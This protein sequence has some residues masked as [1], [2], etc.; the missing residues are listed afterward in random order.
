M[1]RYDYRTRIY[2][3]D[4]DRMDVVYYSRY[5]E[6]FE[7]ART[8][9]LNSIGFPVKRIEEEGFFL[10]V[11]TSHCE[12]RQGA[13][14]ED[15]IVVETTLPVLPKARLR[16]DY[17]VRRSGEKTTLVRGYTEHAFIDQAGQPSRPPQAF[18]S[19][20]NALF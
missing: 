9:L 4:V 20:L 19:T 14:F 5:L 17:R 2:Y 18:M 15:Q 16:I 7:A 10:P 3:R 13:H 8:E 11:V 6:L 12:Y 1:I